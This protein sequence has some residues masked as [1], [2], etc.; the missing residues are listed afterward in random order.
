MVQEEGPVA[1]V[2]PANVMPDAPATGA[3]VPPHP[4]VMVTGV[5]TT[6]PVGNESVKAIPVRPT[7][8]FG[9]AMVN[10]KVELLFCG[11]LDGVKDL[12]MVGGA[13]TVIVALAV[14]PLPASTDVTAVVMLLFTPAVVPVTLTEN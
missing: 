6:M 11:M 12:L 10:A 1:M 14:L 2:P 9:L 8:V 5:A 7:V 4:L 3:N 13:A